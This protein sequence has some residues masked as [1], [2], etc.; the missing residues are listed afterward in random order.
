MYKSPDGHVFDHVG[1]AAWHAL[2][3]RPDLMGFYS[4]YAP[5]TVQWL[6]FQGS[7]GNLDRVT[8][9]DSMLT[10]IVRRADYVKIEASNVVA[11]PTL[12]RSGR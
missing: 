3:A 10:Q 2:R 6:L 12:D 4:L 11:F 1:E 7:A 9:F 5:L 8:R